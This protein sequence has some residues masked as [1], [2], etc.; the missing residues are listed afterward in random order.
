[1][2]RVS[3]LWLAFPALSV[4]ALMTATLRHYGRRW[5]LDHPNERSLHVT[6]V[7]RGGGLAL[8]TVFLISIVALWHLNQANHHELF[9]SLT[10]AGAL[11]AATG[12]WDDHINVR[13]RW[14]L[15]LHF[16]AAACAVVLLGPITVVVLPGSALNFPTSVGS[17]LTVMGLM[18]LLN[19]YNFM[20]GIDGLAGAEA[21]SV[22]LPAALLAWHYGIDLPGLL[23]LAAASAGF[24][25]FNW[26]PARIF[27]GDVGSGFVGF[28]FGVYAVASAQIAPHW[29]WVWAIL[30][31]VFWV[32]ATVT[33][34]RRIAHGQ[35]PY[36]AHRT[37][38]YQNVARRL[39]AHRPVT[40]AIVAINVLYLAPLAGVAA[41]FP[42][43]SSVAALVAV[44]PL[45][46]AAF[47]F[48]AGQPEHLQPGPA[49]T[50]PIPS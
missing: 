25:I 9:M 49:A 37:H 11:V 24:L 6:P 23:V 36:A 10:L 16:G 35:A 39:G 5:L 40:L 13:A 31:A 17:A 8:A 29:L 21:V 38:A 30:L 12:Y 7:P 14:R 2:N 43:W 1:M 41:Q 33:L 28:V 19:L 15:L 26:P 44:L 32:D 22:A 27:M 18:W 4:A 20:D 50:H 3:E 47:V 45:I 42:E 48:R 46:L 34:L